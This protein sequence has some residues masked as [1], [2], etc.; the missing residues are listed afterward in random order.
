MPALLEIAG[1]ALILAGC[2]VVWLRDRARE[3]EERRLFALAFPDNK[4]PRS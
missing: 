4:E 2:L 3:R 1:G